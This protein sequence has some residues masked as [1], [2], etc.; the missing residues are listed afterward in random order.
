MCRIRG[1]RC[2]C[3]CLYIRLVDRSK[4]YYLSSNFN[5]PRNLVWQVEIVLAIADGHGTFEI[6]RCAPTSTPTVW[7][8]RDRYLDEGRPDLK[9]D[10]T[11]PSRVPPLLMET[12]LKV[13]AKTFQETPSNATHWSRALITEAMG[14]LPLSVGRVWA[15]A[16]FKA[17][18]RP[19]VY[20]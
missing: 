4:L 19:S 12:R 15:E 20:G 5:T 8:W 11:H 13:I 7:R 3:I 6:M 14:I 18:V 1:D 9:L 16:A 17:S 2:D 10:K